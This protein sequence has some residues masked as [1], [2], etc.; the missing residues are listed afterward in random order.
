MRSMSGHDAG[1]RSRASKARLA[2]ATAW[3]ANRTRVTT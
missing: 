1:V 3:A 2:L